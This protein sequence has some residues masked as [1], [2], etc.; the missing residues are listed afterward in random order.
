MPAFTADYYPGTKAHPA[1]L[2][3]LGVLNGRRTPIFSTTVTGKREARQLAADFG[4][5]PWN[6]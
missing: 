2:D 5:T 3:I 4:A 1:A 6:F